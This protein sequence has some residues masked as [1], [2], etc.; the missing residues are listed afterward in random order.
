MKN[1][2]IKNLIYTTFS[3]V[4]FATNQSFAENIK[5]NT[6]ADGLLIH[7]YDPVA[8]HMKGEASLGSER[9]QYK[10]QGAK[11]L[12][13]SEEN[14]TKFVANPQQYIPSYG[15]FCSYGVRSG[16]YSDSDP[17]AFKF[18]D[19][20]LFLMYNKGTELLWLKDV[21]S[22]IEVADKVWP[23]MSQ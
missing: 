9:Y 16:N 21:Q 19:N 1:K 7:G 5:L 2:L 8:Y 11:I 17:T 22:N 14:K 15:G 13:S 18:V 10:Y 6:N 20:R 3:L 12:F 4:L 23:S